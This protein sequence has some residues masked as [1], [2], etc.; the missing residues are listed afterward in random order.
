MTTK[1]RKRKRKK[2][3]PPRELVAIVKLLISIKLGST[4]RCDPDIDAEDPTSYPGTRKIKTTQKSDETIP[5]PGQ[6]TLVH[7]AAAR[8]V[9]RPRVFI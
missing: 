2:A 3:Q 5:N 1:S 8:P 7:C 4:W 9:A 6:E